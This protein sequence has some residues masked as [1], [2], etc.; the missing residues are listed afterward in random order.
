MSTQQRGGENLNYQLLNF[1]IESR[2]LSK[3]TVAEE[4]GITRQ[5]LYNKLNGEREFKGSEIKKL[6]QMLKL[7]EQEQQDI[8]FADEIDEDVHI[9]A[10]TETA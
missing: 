2:G 5:G 4:L 6:I 8:F 9:T 7:D 1:K 3:S 10:K